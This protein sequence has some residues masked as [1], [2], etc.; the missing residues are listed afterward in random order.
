MA[1]TEFVGYESLETE[2]KLLSII[3]DGESVPAV[4][5][6][7]C[8]LIFDKTPFYGEG[9]GQVGDTGVISGAAEATVTDTKK[10]GGVYLHEAKIESGEYR[11]GESYTL[12]V[13]AARRAAIKRNHSSAHL[14]QAAL[15]ATLGTHVEQ[16]GSYVDEHRVRF[17][18]T[19]LAA[20]THEEIAAV[21][22]IVNKNILLAEAASTTVCD[23]ETARNMGAMALFGEKYGDTVRVVRI[24]S[25]S[26]ELCG[27]THVSNTG[28]IGLFKIISESSVAAGVR[29]IE[30]T[31]GLG[32]LA[33][34][35]ERDALIAECARELKSPN[36]NA[37]AKRASAVM[38]EAKELRREIESLGARISEMQ[39]EKLLEGIEKV[40]G[41]ELLTAKL[42]MRPDAARTLTDTFKSKHPMGVIVLAAVAD[43]KLNFV[44]AA[45]ADAVKA[46]A[47]AG[48]I[49]GEIAQICGGKGGGRPNS[50]MSGG[51]DISK[52]NEA[53]EQVKIILAR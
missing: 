12:T 24:G 7:E 16:A 5:E 43:G 17:D 13:D 26:I 31:T 44:A 38:G 49:V 14:L 23:I 21:E 29:R 35:G 10:L 34:L 20:M 36:P 11:V 15:R 48:K 42:D 2:A 25:S 9:G 1:A 3:L 19:H 53:L 32:V 28:E 51:K 40:G 30:G 18:F 8:T 39:A 41:F 52:A 47:H 6:G 22:A 45:G 50:A 46:G 33:L 37:I 4:S 27:G